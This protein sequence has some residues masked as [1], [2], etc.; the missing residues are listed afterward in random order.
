MNKAELY[1]YLNA[2]GVKYEVVEHPPAMTVDDILGFGLS[3]PELIAKNLF[4]R[5]DKK[6]N[7]YLLT[8]RHD[9]TVSIKSF[10]E[11]AGTRKLSFASEDDLM[12]LLG[13]RRGAVTPFGLL[14][15]AQCEVKLYLDS[16]YDGGRI[17]IH[18]NENTASVYIATD[19]LIRLLR[20]HGSEVQF[21]EV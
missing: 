17:C 18:P 21:I 8:V 3:E 20:A 1:E 14:N 13:L 6:R 10:Q 7:Y 9:L 12:R 4:L 11:K 2:H 16:Y 5:D 15:D 19:D